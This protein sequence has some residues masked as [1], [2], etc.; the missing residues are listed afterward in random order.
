MSRPPS[1]SRLLF[2]FAVMLCVPGV[3]TADSWIRPK[4]FTVKSANGKYAAVVVP[5]GVGGKRASVRLY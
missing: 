1:F 3:T 4:A 2:A 5:G